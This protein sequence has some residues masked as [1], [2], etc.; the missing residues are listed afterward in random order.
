MLKIY[1]RFQYFALQF[2]TYEFLGYID[3]KLQLATI[4]R[5]NE[6]LQYIAACKRSLNAS[7]H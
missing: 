6:M 4:A 5:V 3:S 1:I 2:R 7:S